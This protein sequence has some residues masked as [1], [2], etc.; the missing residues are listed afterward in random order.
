MAN[1]NTNLFIF[2]IMTASIFFQSTLSHAQ[3]LQDS[4]P[5]TTSNACN[6]VFLSYAYTGGHQIPPTLDPKNQPYRFESSVTLLNNGLH[7]L[8]S[9]KVFLGFQHNEVL[10]SA[11][12]SVLADGASLPAHVGNGVVLS[13][14]AVKDLKS[15]VKTA[16]DVNQRGVVIQLVGTQFGV[17]P[18]SVP[19][20]GNMSLV[21]HGYS[22]SSPITQGIY[23][24][25]YV[26]VLL[27]F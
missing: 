1:H 14:S 24:C 11:S 12:D 7:E 13:G 17:G 26:Y 18:P 27:V 19:M 10:V 6:G 21:N 4:P 15:A 5:T 8:K 20:P 2:L 16:D 22:C 9:W 3:K 23:M 25:V